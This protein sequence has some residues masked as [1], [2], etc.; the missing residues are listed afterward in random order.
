MAVA[1]PA[2][3]EQ[4]PLAA[5]L[6][7]AVAIAFAPIFFRWSETAPIATAFWR[8]ALATPFLWLIARRAGSPAGRGGPLVGRDRLLLVLAG[9]LFAGDMIFWHW[10]LALSSVANATLLANAAPVFVVIGGYLLY[11]RTVTRLFLAGMATAIAGAAILMDA[12]FALSA[13]RLLGDFFGVVTAVF[14][15]AYMLCIERLAGRLS[16]AAI[17]IVSTA[18]SALV[19]LPVALIETGPFFPETARGWAVLIGLALVAQVIGQTLVA[20]GLGR[21]P[22]HFGSVSLLLQPATAALLAWLLV[23]EPMGAQ[24]AVGAVVI[25]AGILLAR[26]GTIAPGARRP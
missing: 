7:G 19:C 6:A 22:V 2:R 1:L 20:Y 24:Q 18:V 3:I 10:S 9:V 26:R 21:L 4:V 15:G 14:Y 25:L 12:S 11:R 13:T 17:M 5:L 16:T 23:A 8:F